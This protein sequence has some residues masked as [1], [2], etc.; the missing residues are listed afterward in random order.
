MESGESTV[1]ASN[2]VYDDHENYEAIP[3]PLRDSYQHL[4]GW[5]LSIG[6]WLLADSLDRLG[7]FGGMSETKMSQRY[8]LANQS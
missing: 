1:G 8:K 3:G 6:T 2:E 5:I 7:S 4:D